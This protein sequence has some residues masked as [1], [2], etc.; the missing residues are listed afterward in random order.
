L[1]PKEKQQR[2]EPKPNR[3]TAVGGD[4]GNHIEVEDGDD[5]QE[6]EVGPAK[7]AAEMG[8]FGAGGCKRCNFG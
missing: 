1:R 3:Y 4:R 8:S 5:E 2:D 6:D 7:D